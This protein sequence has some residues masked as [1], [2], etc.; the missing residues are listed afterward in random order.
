MKR[1]TFCMRVKHEATYAKA[2]NYT[3]TVHYD[4]RQAGYAGNK[5][6]AI[7]FGDH[8]ALAAKRRFPI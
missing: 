3:T 8:V 6:S 4:G 7:P 5:T 2:P 1:F